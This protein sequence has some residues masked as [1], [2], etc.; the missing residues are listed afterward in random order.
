MHSVL[1]ISIYST[2]QNVIFSADVLVQKLSRI[3]TIQEKLLKFFFLLLFA[4]DHALFADD[5]TLFADDHSNKKK[6]KNIS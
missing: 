2:N 4:D 1:K 3:I 6:Y 5:H